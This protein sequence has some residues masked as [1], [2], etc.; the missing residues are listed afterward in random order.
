M[1][2]QAAL[3]GVVG[4]AL[5]A[6]LYTRP[7]FVV[8]DEA[9]KTTESPA[10]SEDTAVADTKGETHTMA[11]LTKEQRSQLT[12]FQEE[13]QQAKGEKVSEVRRS[14]G[15]V[16]LQAMAFDSA[17]Y[18]FE[19]IAVT[20]NKVGDWEL[21]GDTY[22]Q[23]FG[24]AL[25]SENIA[26]LA[27]KVQLC[28]GKVLALKPTALQAKTNLAMT[29]VVSDSPMQA[30]TTLRQVLEIE[31]NFE[32]ALMNLGVLSMQSNQFDKA[33]DR[34]RAVLRVNPN[35][36]NAQVGLAYSLIE[37]KEKAQA[38]VLLEELLA[39]KDLEKTLRDEVLNTLQ[40]LK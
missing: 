20:S 1:K 30:I 17:A 34:F 25:R 16:Y 10:S 31:P 5:T 38:K 40:S 7:K 21:A 37:L 18:F 26:S 36:H 29:Y 13:L 39:H 23:A 8:K 22:F 3:L 33:A 14:I 6:F 12:V 4:I 32:P 15:Q 35:N 19:Q 27:K 11:Q 24:L 28:Y 2:K 9:K